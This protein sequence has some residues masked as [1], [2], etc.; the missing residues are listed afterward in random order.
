MIKKLTRKKKLKPRPLNEAE[1]A[2]MNKVRFHEQ[3]KLE[4]AEIIYN[5]LEYREQER[6]DTEP[7]ELEVQPIDD[8]V[9]K[10]LP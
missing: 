9:K 10:H 3:E 1:K 5:V 7:K 2:Y 8:I 6:R 4:Q